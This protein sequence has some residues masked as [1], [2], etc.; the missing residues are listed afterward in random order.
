MSVG[1]QYLSDLYV[2]TYVVFLVHTRTYMYL[3]TNSRQ[4]GL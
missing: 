3:H 1:V 4:M 2:R